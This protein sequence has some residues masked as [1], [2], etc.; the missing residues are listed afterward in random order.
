MESL[1]KNKQNKETILK[2]VA[3]YFTPLRMESF[4]EL[5]E[6]YF[7]MAYE[8]HLS[9]EEQVILKIAPSKEMCVMTYEKN[10]MFSEV[11]AMKLAIRHGGIPVPKMIGYD[12]SCTICDSPYFFMEKLEGKSL[13]AVKDS[14]SREQINRIHVETGE[15]NKRINDILGPVFGYPGQPEFQGKEWYPIFHK[16]ME[17]GV[18]DAQSGNVDL[19]IPISQ[20]WRCLDRDKAVFDEVTEPKLVHWDC[21]DGNI[22]VEAEKVTGIIDWERSLW[23]DPLMEVGFRTFSDNTYFQ[24]G[25]GIKSLTEKQ[26]RRALWYDI[27][28]MLLVA[29]EFEYR[30]YETMD[31]YHYSTQLLMEQFE[32]VKS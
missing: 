32:K 24:K 4:H 16:M 22:F 14:L 18:N 8:I 1:T 27:Y 30:K 17:A 7:N 15:I 21:W 3:K 29:L 28:L 9:N 31:S 12:D 5:T 20:M 13:N 26:K 23:G 19:K 11:E 10:I 25:Y 2:M 6:G